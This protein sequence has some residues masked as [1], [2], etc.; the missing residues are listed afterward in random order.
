MSVTA[1]PLSFPGPGGALQDV[2]F[3]LFPNTFLL[4][5]ILVAFFD[6]LVPTRLE[7]W[8]S[9]V[10]QPKVL[11]AVLEPFCTQYSASCI[12]VTAGVTTADS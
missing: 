5:M 3:G 8:G 6:E 4:S 1:H 12:F 10:G 2:I 7:R 9:F 11:S